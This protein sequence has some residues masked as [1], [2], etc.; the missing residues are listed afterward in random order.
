MRR[1]ALSGALGSVLGAAGMA[2]AGFEPSPLFAEAIKGLVA[3]GPVAVVLGV[4]IYVVWHAYQAKDR[5]LDEV[6]ADQTK[7][8][9]ELAKE[10]RCDDP[11]E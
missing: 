5:K 8:F 1:E 9:R 7:F 10:D 4:A 11:G 3:S 2:A 6:H